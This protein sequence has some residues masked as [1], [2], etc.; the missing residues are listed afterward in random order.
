VN[1]VVK[2]GE[3]IRWNDSHAD[4]RCL[5]G[6][7]SQTT[8]AAFALRFKTRHVPRYLEINERDKRVQVLTVRHGA[9]DRFSRI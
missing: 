9:R 7:K 1:K 4:A 5:G 8:L 3:F 2:P 6:E